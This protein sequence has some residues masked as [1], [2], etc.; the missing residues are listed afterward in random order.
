MATFV[1]TNVGLYYGGYSLASNFNAIGLNMSANMVDDT[2]YGDIF[3]SNTSGLSSVNLE[4]EGYWDSTPDSV[5]NTSLGVADTV[6]SVTPVDQAVGSPALFTKLMSSEYNPMAV[7]TVGEM[8]GF[9]LSGESQ[10]EKVI[11]GEIMVAPGTNR[12]STSTSAV[13]NL[14]AVSATQKIYS[15]IHVISAS[16]T[17]DVTVKSDDGSGFSSPTTRITHTQFTGVGAE[18]KSADGAITDAYWRVDFAVSGG[19][20]FDTIISIG[21][22]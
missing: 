3:Q 9:R 18:L 16:G 11:H 8:M 14:G 19:G 22:I 17:F 5:L 4:A 12:T 1:Q 2:V 7:G 13:N 21:I 20:S 10:G 6:T 15:A